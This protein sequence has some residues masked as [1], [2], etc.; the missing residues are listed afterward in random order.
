MMASDQTLAD[1]IIAMAKLSPGEQA[2]VISVVNRMQ[3]NLSASAKTL[4]VAGKAPNHGKPIE[5]ADRHEFMRYAYMCQRTPC[6]KRH[7]I[8][9]EAARVMG[10]SYESVR[11]E[12]LRA[13][14]KINESKTIKSERAQ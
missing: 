10:R 3:L 7:R 2:T 1:A 12:I 13:I 6:K 5:D 4:P 14:R 8:Y 9:N 11:C